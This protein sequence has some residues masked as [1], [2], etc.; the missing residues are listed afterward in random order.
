MTG[1]NVEGTMG[2][3]ILS[4]PDQIPAIMS[5]SNAQSIGRRNR[6]DDA[7]MIPR[8][9][10]V[11][12]FS[13]AAHVTGKQNIDFIEA[14]RAPHII[15][16]HGEKSQAARLKSRLLD[17]N[18]KRTASNADV[19]QTKVYSPENGA[20][21][22]IP[23]R[24]DK[25]A[26]VVGRLAQNPA[27]TGPED[28]RVISGVMVQNG[29][30]LSL[31]APEDLREYAG[32][33]STTVLCR[34][35]ITLSAAGVDLIKWALEGTFGAIEEVGQVKA[36][37]NGHVEQAN[38]ST[39]MEV[40]PKEEEA[41]VE[42]ISEPPRT[43]LIMGCITLKW[44]GQA[45]EIEL[46]WEGNTMNDGIADAVMAVLTTVESSPAAVKYSSSKAKHH[47]HHVPKP[48]EPE[49]KIM[50][51]VNGTI[52]G[53]HKPSTL[54]NQLAHLTPEERFSRLCMFLEEQFGDNITPIETPRISHLTQPD[55][56][57]LRAEAS[58]YDDSE[59]DIDEAELEQ[60]NMAMI[61]SERARLA[62]LGIPVPGLEIKV[63]KMVAR[64]WLDDLT[65]ECASKVWRERILAVVERAVE[66]V[67][68][69]WSVG[70]GAGK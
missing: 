8:R 11:E 10:S 46:E 32:L 15:L 34:Q 42:F 22:K 28:E 45:K 59:E 23:F 48:E 31:M 43:F 61:A 44:S 54:R 49:D 52:N 9:C 40:A 55:S 26:K 63:D 3:T 53:N 29:F 38:G 39:K 69:L 16:V 4:E 68:P 35:H 25:I 64:L 57:T 36:E 30:K 65:L 18:S 20:E 51:R 19:Q 7:V 17:N 70:N 13:F 67:A 47:H 5:G 1:Y 14:V 56:K 12:E 24:K 60:R 66:V 50:K 21:I 27:P 37:T 33:T 58:A 41:D 62:A 2:R 6:D